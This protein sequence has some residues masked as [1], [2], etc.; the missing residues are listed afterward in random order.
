VPTDIEAT[1][2][3][4]ASLVDRGCAA[5]LDTE[6]RTAA[7]RLLGDIARGDPEVFRRRGRTDTAAAA[8]TWIVAKANDRLGQ[9]RGGLTATALARWFGVSGSPSQRASTLL[10]AVGISAAT[11]GFGLDLGTPR[12]LTSTRRRAILRQADRSAQHPRGSG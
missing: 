5:L 11:G 12:Y 1:V 10:R 2:R 6:C 8:V 4:V 9:D 7:R 3:E